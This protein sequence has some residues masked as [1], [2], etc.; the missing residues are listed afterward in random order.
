VGMRQVVDRVVD[1]SA[2]PDPPRPPGPMAQGNRLAVV[3]TGASGWLGRHLVRAL[4]QDLAVAQVTALVRDV[5]RAQNLWT[6]SP[7][8]QIG[9]ATDPGAW[10]DPLAGRGLGCHVG[11]ARGESVVALAD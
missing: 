2:V 11:F 10:L 7:K 5:T 8:L 9:M 6:P 3:V 1:V 4:L